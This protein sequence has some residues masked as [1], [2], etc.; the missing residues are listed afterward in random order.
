MYKNESVDTGNS[1]PCILLVD[2]QEINL[3]IL[4]AA[5][6]GM[7]ELHTATDGHQALEILHKHHQTIDLVLLD[8]Q[9]P[10]MDG[11]QALLEIRQSD[12]LKNIPVV[13]ITAKDTAKDE[14]KGLELGAMDY[15][16]KPFN[17]AVVHARIRNQ[18][19]LKKKSDLLEKLA[20]LD[21]LTEI[22]NRRNY[23]HT[24]KQEW[25][26]AA[27]TNSP[28]SLIML[29]IDYFKQYN[30][31]YGHSLG[32]ET[33]KAVAKCLSEQVMRSGDH[34]ARYG[35]EEFVVVLPNTDLRAA[36][37]VAEKIR[38]A[39]IN[40]QIRHAFSEVSEYIT[41]SLGVSS[42]IPN[43]SEPYIVLQE[44]A[45][46]ALYQAKQAGRNQVS[47]AADSQ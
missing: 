46:Q 30:D 35:G 23:D 6:S 39:I 44:Q 32:D 5:L 3:H 7:Y 34:A 20:L 37:K 19:A 24:I 4:K 9:M 15:I 8:I 41:V 16:T 29:D 42:T 22:P 11:Y 43:I 40:L 27:R 28:I 36:S 2:D 26:R 45:D 12:D 10:K 33:L 18:L 1:R 17:M 31:N 25:R 47:S 21:G 14:A 38:E 13:F